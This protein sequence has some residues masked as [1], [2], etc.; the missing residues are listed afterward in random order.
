MAA[1]DM[2]LE[3]RPLTGKGADKK[4]HCLFWEESVMAIVGPVM[5]PLSAW[6]WNHWGDR[7]GSVAVRVLQGKLRDDSP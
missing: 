7:P 2:Q 3:M 6:V 4:V 1:G 5:V